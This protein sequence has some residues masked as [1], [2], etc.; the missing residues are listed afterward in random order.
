M[1]I[2]HEQF[3][4]YF[5]KIVFFKNQYCENY[6]FNYFLFYYLIIFHIAIIISITLKNNFTKERGLIYDIYGYIS[7][8]NSLIDKW[9]KSKIRKKT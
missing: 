8:M 7:Y 6:L 4:L 5:F 9:H 3:F 2:V 1:Q